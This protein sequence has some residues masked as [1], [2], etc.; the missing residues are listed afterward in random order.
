[1]TWWSY[2]KP[3]TRRQALA[4]T[5]ATLGSVAAGT[6]QVHQRPDQGSQPP[7]A[8]IAPSQAAGTLRARVV[9]VSGT[10]A[11]VF[12][13]S[14]T[15]GAGNLIASM[16]QAS[17]DPFGN[18]TLT[19]GFA[20]YSS[21]DAVQYA[22]HGV[23]YFTGSLASGWSSGHAGLSFGADQVA[24]TAGPGA[25]FTFVAPSGDTSGTT[26][27]ATLNAIGGGATALLLPGTFYVDAPVVLGSATAL[28]GVFTGTGNPSANFGAGSLPLQPVVI[29]A[30]PG[31][32]GAGIITMTSSGSQLGGQ[33][34][35][36]ITVDGS[37]I[38]GANTIHG[39][40]AVG[41]VAQVRISGVSV[42][43]GNSR[44]MGGDALHLNSN[45]DGNPDAW[46]V[47]DSQFQKAGGYGVN[48]AAGVAD[49][50]WDGISCT[51]NGLGGWFVVN[52]NDSRYVACKGQTSAAGYG[53]VLDGVIGFS[54][55]V[56]FSHCGTGSNATGGWSLEGGGSGT[57]YL[58]WNRADEATPWTYAGSN[59]VRTPA[60]YN[61]ST[62]TPTF[63]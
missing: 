55:R 33:V 34:I 30:T 41:A 51:A 24:V 19:G 36:G 61:T 54:G 62:V 20:T 28:V 10:G 7:V 23:T 9:I 1:M 3:P 6:G 57:Y 56:Y 50:L 46:I 49:S 25:G 47:R 52:G 63:N 8:A 35:Q 2:R 11:G 32:T 44:V 38:S 21:V 17:T 45:G 60:A 16:T 48:M 13:Y 58:D 53:F 5:A 39:I 29:Q 27:T 4:G 40:S 31:F 12:L 59:S 42:Y 37:Q 43:G 15:P 26:D 14:G 18:H 22:S